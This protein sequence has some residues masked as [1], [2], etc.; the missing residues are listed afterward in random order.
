[1]GASPVSAP[2][3][4]K[5]LIAARL[6]SAGSQDIVFDGLR[7]GRYVRYG[8]RAKGPGRLPPTLYGSRIYCAGLRIEE[9]ATSKAAL[10]K[11]VVEALWVAHKA[12]TWSPAATPGS[13]AGGATLALITTSLDDPDAMR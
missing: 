13:P 7:L 4:T 5:A 11:K 2:R 9:E 8:G 6:T 1:M 12:G 3:L 10:L